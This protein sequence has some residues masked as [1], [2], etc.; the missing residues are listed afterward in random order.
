MAGDTI[1]GLQKSVVASVKHYIGNEQELNRNA[2]IPIIGALKSTQPVSSNIDDRTMHE[3]YLWPFQDAIKAGAASVMCSYNKVCFPLREI[4]G[5]RN[6]RDCVVIVVLTCIV[7]YSI[8][9]IVTNQKN[10]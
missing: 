6:S 2:A 4:Q 9:G 10:R 1:T 8:Y 7:S 3:M 5:L